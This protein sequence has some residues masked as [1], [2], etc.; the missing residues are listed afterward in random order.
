MAKNAAAEDPPPDRPRPP[1]RSSKT[2]H[3]TVYQS[4]IVYA[5]HAP[6]SKLLTEMKILHTFPP[7]KPLQRVAIE[8]RR[9][10]TGGN[11]TNVNHTIHT[12]RLKF[13]QEFIL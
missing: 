8:L 7:Q 5:V 9:I 11:A 3:P 2:P 12:I 6:R 4:L 13:R 10:L 1:I